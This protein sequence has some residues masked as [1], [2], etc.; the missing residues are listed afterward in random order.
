VQAPKDVVL[1]QQALHL[2]QEL[3]QVI[4]EHTQA[5]IK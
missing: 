1:E 3:L 2:N 4:M 5:I